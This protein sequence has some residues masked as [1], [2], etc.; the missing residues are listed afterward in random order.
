MNIKIE[1]ACFRCFV[2]RLN[3]RFPTTKLKQTHG[4]SEGDGETLLCEVASKDLY[5]AMT[6]TV[7]PSLTHL[8]VLIA[9]GLWSHTWIRHVLTIYP[10]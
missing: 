9:I 8:T 2:C 3:E 1:K 5:V 6:A 10:H 4:N 7:D